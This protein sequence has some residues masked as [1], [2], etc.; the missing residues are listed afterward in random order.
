VPGLAG[1]G[2]GVAAGVLGLAVAP[3]LLPVGLAGAAVAAGAGLVRPRARRAKAARTEQAALE[4][5]DATSYLAFHIRRVEAS[6][7]PRLRETVETALAEHRVARAAWHDLVGDI[8][9]EVAVSRRQEIEAYSEAL[10]NLGETAEELEQLRRQLA[11]GAEPR[12][13]AARDAA[14]SACRPYLLDD[15]EDDEPSTWPALV[16]EQCRRGAAARLQVEVDDAET[17]EHDA[18]AALDALLSELGFDAGLLDARVGGLEWAVSRATEREEAR[19][20]ARPREEIESELQQLQA[21]AAALHR[22]EW[23]TVTAAE[24][25][26][27]DIAELEARRSELAAEVAAARAEVDIERLADRHAAVERRVSALEARLGGP[28]ANGDP[29]AIADMQQ[30]LLAHLTAASQAGPDGDSVPVILDEVF[31]RVPAD[32][33]WDLLDLLHRLAEKHQVIYLSDDAFVAAW[34]RQR[35]GDGAITLLELAPEPV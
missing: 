29:G 35:A 26:T 13:R 8:D 3:V 6:V 34:A 19:L 2:L 1:T 28:A 24:A 14:V 4:R 21:T 20:R 27:P 31:Q 32:R 7:D 9:V 25:S 10:R 17:A 33:K 11:E 5:A 23:E 22:P 12:L 15:L 30:N 18:S 16:H